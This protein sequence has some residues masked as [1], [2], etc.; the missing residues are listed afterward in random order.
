MPNNIHLAINYTSDYDYTRVLV[1]IEWKLRRI[2]AF[3][4]WVNS[5]QGL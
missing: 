2:L 4:E 5:D 1:E 3:A